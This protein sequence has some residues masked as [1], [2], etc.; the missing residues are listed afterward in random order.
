MPAGAGCGGG[1]WGAGGPPALGTFGSPPRA[2]AL[3]PGADGVG[4]GWGDAGLKSSLGCVHSGCL[5]N[6]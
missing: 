5:T 2:A 3:A 6:T 1:S 4:E